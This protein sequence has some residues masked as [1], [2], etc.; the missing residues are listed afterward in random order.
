MPL[1]APIVHFEFGVRDTPKAQAFYGPLF[2]WQF[3]QAGPACMVTNIGPMA[4]GNKDVCQPGIGGHIASLGHPP[5]TY[6]VV[7][8][9]VDD[10]AATIAHAEK[11]GGRSLVPPTE[12]PNLGSFAWIGD[13][14]GNTVGLWKP[15]IS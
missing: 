7:Y 12:V 1:P 14:E 10:L 8:A 4:P 11:L 3:V 6:C 9:Q 13:P 5:H 15:L 2:G